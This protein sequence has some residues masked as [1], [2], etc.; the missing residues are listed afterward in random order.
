[1]F[2]VFQKQRSIYCCKEEETD[3][4]HYRFYKP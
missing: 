2:E 4:Q 3:L 1:M